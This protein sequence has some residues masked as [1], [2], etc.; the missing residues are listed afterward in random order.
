MLMKDAVIMTTGALHSFL[1]EPDEPIT[2]RNGQEQNDNNHGTIRGYDYN[3]R[4]HD[5]YNYS[6]HDDYNYS[7]HDD[8]NYKGHDY[9]YRG[10]D[11]YDYRRSDRHNYGE[12]RPCW[13]CS[14]P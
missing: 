3:C 10:R 2:N 6:G 11:D 9:S 7:G 8:Y 4:G 14:C 13:F 12:N 5:D 1:P